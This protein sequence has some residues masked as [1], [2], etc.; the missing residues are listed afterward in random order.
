MLIPLVE[1]ALRSPPSTLS[2]FGC[3]RDESRGVFASLAVLGDFALNAAFKCYESG[4][5]WFRAKTPRTAKTQRTVSEI[6][7]LFAVITDLW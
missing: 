6:G 2:A 5:G 7:Q 1:E 4:K 3:Q